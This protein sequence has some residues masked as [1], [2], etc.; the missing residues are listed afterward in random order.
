MWTSFYSCYFWNACGQSAMSQAQE[1]AQSDFF[2]CRYFLNVLLAVGHASAA[3]ICLHGG[4]IT[5]TTT[6]SLRLASLGLMLCNLMPW[7]LSML[8][9]HTWRRGH[10]N[11]LP[12]GLVVGGILHPQWNQP[13]NEIIC[14]VLSN[15]LKMASKNLP[16]WVGD[17]DPFPPRKLHVSDR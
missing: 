17:V 11:R 10:A 15:P 8:Y 9:G 7:G 1:W 2:F 6:M 16:S 4:G 3:Y 13:R 5:S 12:L 14:V